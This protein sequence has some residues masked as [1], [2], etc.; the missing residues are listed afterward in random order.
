MLG[1]KPERFGL[2]D[3]DSQPIAVCGKTFIADQSGALYWP[4]ERTLIVADLH[5]EKASSYAGRGQM[6]PPYDTRETLLNLA[7][8]IDRYE[9]EAVI[10][11]GDN[12]HDGDAAGRISADDLDILRLMQEDRDW[13]WING[14]HDPDIAPLL[15]GHA[16]DEILIEGIRFVHRPG[17]GRVTHEIAAHL[18]PA[19]R[20]SMHGHTI[21]RPCFIGNG[22]R[23]VLPAFG[24]LTGGLNVLD[25]AFLPLFGHDGFA[26]WMLGDEGLYPVATRQLC[27]D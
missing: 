20:L 2:R 12:L 19:A 4:S 3:F 15:G 27:G 22:R 9:A 17:P 8:A 13:V 11:L 24:A 21:R 23:L 10:A 5:L 25:E 14:N 16:F 26:V 6:L 18:H 7:K 1:L